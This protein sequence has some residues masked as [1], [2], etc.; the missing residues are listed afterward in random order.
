MVVLTIA[1]GVDR[2]SLAFGGNAATTTTGP[3]ATQQSSGVTV[4]LIGVVGTFDLAVDVLGLLSGQFRVAA[5]RQVGP[6]GGLARGGHPQRR[7][8]ERHRHRRRLRPGRRRRPAPR[9]RQH[10]RHH[11]P[12]ARASPASCARTTRPQGKNV[13]EN[14]DGT[15][16][17]GIQPGL[18]IRGNGFS[19]GTAELAYGLP[20]QANGRPVDPANAV[21]T[22]GDRRARSP[23]AASSSSTTSGSASPASTVTFGTDPFASFTGAIYIATGGAKLFPGR[24][25][26]A[27]L[28]DRTTADDRRPD[29]S[30]DDEAFRATLTFTDGKVDAFQ[31]VVDTLEIRL[32]TFVTLTARQLPARHRGGRHVAGDGLVHL[33]RRQGHR[34]AARASPARAATS[35]SPATASSRP[36]PASASSSRSGRPPAR[37][38]RGPS[39]CPVRVDAIGIQWEDVENHPEDFVLTL[40][41]SVTGDQGPG[42]AD[43]QRLDPGHQDRA[44]A[45]RPRR[46]PDH[47]AG[48]HRRAGRAARCSAASS[49]PAC[50]A[51][52]SSST[53]AYGIIGPLDTTTPVVQAG[54]L[55]RHRGRLQDRRAGRVQ[56]PPR[57]QRARAAAGVHQRRGPRRRHGRAAGRPGHQ[58]LRRRRRVLQDAAL[59]RGPVRAARTG[60]RPAD[61]RQR[62]ELARPRCRPRSPRRP[63]RSR[64]TPTATASSRPS[65]R[66]W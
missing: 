50:S 46:V 24:P 4:D 56:D 6:A 11:L 3:S 21:T 34:R 36:R 28:T 37:P 61:Q 54:L 30:Q 22:P 63:R 10:R 60:L 9:R 2:A 59:D 14:A 16:G 55:P 40:S 42:R 64:S 19:L 49:T 39:S 35:R 38:S 51:A 53:A 5:D 33:G 45:A 23:S 25:F 12:E 66:R 26:G 13:P 41:A 29:G 1:V 15:I 32:G 57:P 47:R 65:P 7:H 27:S 44:G 52:S 43:V 58:R 31:L 62:R 18:V 8:A 17:A 20:L 48:L